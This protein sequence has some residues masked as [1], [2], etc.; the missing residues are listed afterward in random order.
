ARLA[1]AKVPD[2]RVID[3]VNQTGLLLGK[4]TKGGRDTFLYNNNAVRQ[5]RW[6]Y[7]RAEHKVPGYAQDKEREQVEELYDLEADIG[8]RNNLAAQHPE[9]VRELKKLMETLAKGT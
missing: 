1:G 9:K 7:L 6:K 8:E 3:G 2:D 4:S 5:G